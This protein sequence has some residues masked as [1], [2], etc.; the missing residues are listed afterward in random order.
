[1][2]SHQ[3][4]RSRAVGKGKDTE[5]PA[6]PPFRISWQLCS[7]IS[8][9]AEFSAWTGAFGDIDVR[10]PSIC[11]PP[12]SAERQRRTL[13]TPSQPPATEIAKNTPEAI[14]VEGMLIKPHDLHDFV[15]PRGPLPGKEALVHQRQPIVRPRITIGRGA[16]YGCTGR[17]Y[18]D[19]H[20]SASSRVGPIHRM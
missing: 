20:R 12:V 1:M 7:F 2:G 14:E 10:G 11:D 5:V 17:T 13:D 8:P 3:A 19:C 16:T 4:D 6:G 18:P 15:L 9:V